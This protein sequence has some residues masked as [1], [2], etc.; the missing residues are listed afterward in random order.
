MNT[1]LEAGSMTAGDSSSS[2]STFGDPVEPILP[3]PPDDSCER[4]HFTEGACSEDPCPPW[5][6]PALDQILGPSWCSLPDGQGHCPSNF[7]CAAA[8]ADPT[9]ATLVRCLAFNNPCRVDADC[10]TQSPYCVIDAR[11]SSGSC[12]HG[13]IG[14]RC[15]ADD[16]CQS[17]SHCIAIDQDGTRGC[18]DGAEGSKCNFDAECRGGRCAHPTGVAIRDVNNEPRL[19]V[20]GICT[21]GQ[22]RS[23]CYTDV[24]IC[25]PGKTCVPSSSSAPCLGDL[26]CVKANNAVGGL[27]SSGDVGDPCFKDSDCT[28]QHCPADVDRVCTA[29]AVG[30]PCSDP[31]D[32]E[33][34]ICTPRASLS[35]PFPMQC[36]SGE[37]GEPCV[38]QADCKSGFCDPRTP[39]DSRRLCTN[40]LG[41]SGERCQ[42]DTNCKN[43]VCG[44]TQD[45]MVCINGKVGDLCHE[46]LWCASGFCVFSS[47]SAGAPGDRCAEAADCLS[48]QCALDPQQGISVCG[49]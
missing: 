3:A 48:Q 11:Y 40:R 23:F 4:L 18:T 47:C 45:G 1:A 41:E 33:T 25:P 28:S 24:G 5:P 49:P 43:H 21:I 34:G 9:G 39:G 16:D 13:G 37:P 12:D 42:S 10:S 22:S 26:H 35:S 2:G 14:A 19:P 20:V 7:D 44:Q 29:G 31:S 30:D 27:C 8:E 46:P 17:G 15:R 6:C 38:S 32:C 36:S